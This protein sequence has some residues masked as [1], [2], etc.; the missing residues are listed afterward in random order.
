MM[1]PLYNA[2]REREREREG[3]RGR[4]RER[5]MSNPSITPL[6]HACSSNTQDRDRWISTI[7]KT[8]MEVPETPTDSSY[9]AVCK[10][11]FVTALCSGVMCSV[12][13]NNRYMVIVRE[14]FRT[15]Y[16]LDA[17]PIT[18]IQTITW[19]EEECFCSLKSEHK[20]WILMFRD[21]YEK[22]LEDECHCHFYL[23]LF[24]EGTVICLAAP[25]PHCQNGVWYRQTDDH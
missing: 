7:S 16:T 22:Y 1:I 12:V 25:T 10:V 20:E 21:N 8:A 17:V 19:A 5:E 3:E 6:L 18:E 23:Q 13:V 9:G 24:S 15:A 4:E 14:G 2:E 11:P